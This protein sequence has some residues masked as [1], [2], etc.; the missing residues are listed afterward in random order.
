MPGATQLLLF[1]LLVLNLIAPVR[2][3]GDSVRSNRMMTPRDDSIITAVEEEQDKKDTSSR[4]SGK[5]TGQKKKKIVKMPKGKKQKKLNMSNE[6]GSEENAGHATPGSK[7][8][9]IRSNESARNPR[10]FP[11]AHL[12]RLK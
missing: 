4:K 11:V 7:E 3:V 5:L 1:V 12:V 2:K 6:T 8:P 10:D 9:P